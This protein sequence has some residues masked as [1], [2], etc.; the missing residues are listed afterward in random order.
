M[1]RFRFFLMIYTTVNKLHPS[2]GIGQ[3]SSFLFKL[4]T[5]KGR[6]FL[7][8]LSLSWKL[9]HRTITSYN[10]WMIVWD[11]SLFHPTPKSNPQAIKL[12]I[13]DGEIKGEERGM[14]NMR[15]AHRIFV[16]KPDMQT[17]PNTYA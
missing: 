5:I 16:R 2:D 4:Y 15:N 3:G 7:D 13:N 9:F 17:T 8:C 1:A 14:C 6:K 10:K 11:F 12:S